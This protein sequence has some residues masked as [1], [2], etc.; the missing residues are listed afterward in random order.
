MEISYRI[1]EQEIRNYYENQIDSMQRYINEIEKS[2]H[3]PTENQMKNY[4]INII[5]NKINSLYSQLSYHVNNKEDNHIRS[6]KEF[7]NDNDVYVY[8]ENIIDKI[9]HILSNIDLN[10]N[11]SVNN[12]DR[13]TNWSYVFLFMY[14]YF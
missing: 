14:I 3:I 10:A 13:L 6:I 11:Q 8:I 4:H 12:Q 5:Y 2:N 9:S 1:H 7:S